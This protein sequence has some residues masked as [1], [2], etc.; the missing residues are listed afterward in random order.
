VPDGRRTIK[1]V[2]EWAWEVLQAA[3]V[4]SARGDAELLLEAC[5]GVSKTHLYAHPERELTE[6][7]W[8]R[9]QGLVSRRSGHEPVWYVI[10]R[11]WFMDLELLVDRRVLIPRNET[12]LLAQEAL[13]EARRT[14]RSLVIADICT[15][16]GCLAIFLAL[17]LKNAR[18]FATDVSADALDVARE[19]ARRH[20]VLEAITFLQGS[21]LEPAPSG[22][23]MVVANP[24]Y[25]STDEM[26]HLPPEV[27][28]YEPHLALFAG[29]KGT[30]A[31]EAT[32]AQAA[33]K[34][35]PGGVLMMEIGFGQAEQALA[36]VAGKRCFH[37]IE[38]LKDEAGIDRVV[39]A[40]RV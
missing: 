28:D 19:N 33:A 21:F 20:G 7:E 14:R 12:E 11:A 38:I 4:S 18:L 25:V 32:A 29:R 15:G 30:E 3:G 1:A 6:D 16:S 31:A 2:L 13:A 8:D 36:I 39:K 23:D 17:H 27:R 24:P 22:L 35:T 37:E 26:E 40:R 9:F 34:L 10:G 5:L